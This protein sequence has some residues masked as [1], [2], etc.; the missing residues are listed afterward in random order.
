MVAAGGAGEPGVDV[1][2]FA[3]NAEREQ[4]VGLDLDVLFVGGATAVSDAERFAHPW[5]CSG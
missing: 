1:D 2:P 5:N 4:L 3:W